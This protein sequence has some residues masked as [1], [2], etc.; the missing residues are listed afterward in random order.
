[1]YDDPNDW[2]DLPDEE[3]EQRI[4]ALIEAIAQQAE[5]DESKPAIVN[6]LKLRQ[7]EFT[8]LVMRYL[9]RKH[10]WKVTYRLYQPFRTTGSVT[11]EAK[12]IDIDSPQWFARAAS[13][14]DNTDIYPLV[15]GNV[16][17]TFTFHGLM[18][19]LESG[20]SNG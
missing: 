1:M 6:A 16:R 10:E 3:I 5:R 14:A 4:D 12:C 13:F 11:V 20:G 15:N 17:L 18:M 9:S 8:Y 19:P 2:K 7:L